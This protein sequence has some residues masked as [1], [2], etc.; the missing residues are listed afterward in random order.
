[1]SDPGIWADISA[2]EDPGDWELSPRELELRFAS[3]SPPAPPAVPP[4]TAASTGAT[5][6][7]TASQNQFYNVNDLGLAAPRSPSPS[8]PA[9]RR[10]YQACDPC[11]K[12][13]V[14][15]D[16]GSEAPHHDDMSKDTLC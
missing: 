2:D 3:A 6:S 4:D 12:R 14:K 15:C 9:H 7:A 11:R 13:K 10:G 1:M 8:T 16:L 5:M